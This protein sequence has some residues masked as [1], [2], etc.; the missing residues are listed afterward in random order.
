LEV[1]FTGVCAVAVVTKRRGKH[2]SAARVVLQKQ[3]SCVL[4]LVGVEGT[5]FTAEL[6]ESQSEKRGFV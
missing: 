3:K 1:V 6:V 2:V 4:Y 5:T